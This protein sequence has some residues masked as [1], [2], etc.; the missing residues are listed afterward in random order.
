MRLSLPK[1][2]ATALSVQIMRLGQEQG[3]SE[4]KNR[5][6]EANCTLKEDNFKEEN[7]GRQEEYL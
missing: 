5:S 4:K 7:K 6:N 1:G 3:W 2:K